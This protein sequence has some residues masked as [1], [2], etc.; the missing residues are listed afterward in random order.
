[1]N[2]DSLKLSISRGFQKNPKAIDPDVYMDVLRKVG[3]VNVCMNNLEDEGR[4]FQ[5]IYAETGE[6]ETHYKIMSK[7]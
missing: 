4:K 7:L 6:K 1:M 2:L 5:V 3:F